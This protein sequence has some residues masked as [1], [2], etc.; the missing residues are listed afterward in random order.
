[1]K[2]ISIFLICLIVLGGLMALAYNIPNEQ[3]IKEK[4]DCMNLKFYSQIQDKSLS[5]VGDYLLYLINKCD[6]LE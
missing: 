3:P 2:S 5:P 6:R 1:M 4:A